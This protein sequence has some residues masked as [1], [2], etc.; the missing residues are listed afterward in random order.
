MCHYGYMETETWTTSDGTVTTETKFTDGS[1]VVLM[2]WVNEE[3][4]RKNRLALLSEFEGDNETPIALA[5]Y[6][7]LLFERA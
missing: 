5:R 1:R 3:T 7:E 6:N 2:V 4:K